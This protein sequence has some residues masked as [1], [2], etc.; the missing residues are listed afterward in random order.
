MYNSDDFSSYIF[1]LKVTE[2]GYL[3]LLKI[4]P[5]IHL[6]SAVEMQNLS[7]VDFNLDNFLIKTTYEQEEIAS[8]PNCFI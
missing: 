4:N 5:N 2:I 6:K 8:K 3:N 1:F 7:L